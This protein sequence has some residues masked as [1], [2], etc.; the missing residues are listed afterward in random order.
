MAFAN[1]RDLLVLEPLLMRDVGWSA[2]TLVDVGDV[3]VVGAVAQS[4]SSD[5][6]VAGVSA[7][8]IAVIDGVPAEILEVT[9]ATTLT[10]SRM[11]SVGDETAIP[12]APGSGI[13]VKFGSFS[14]RIF[15]SF[16]ARRLASGWHTCLTRSLASRK[17]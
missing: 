8:M 14:P 11:R 2:Q 17:S 12:P 3:S 16:A 7:G 1:D 4:L 5:F 10:V 15:I 9:S 13:I 6:N